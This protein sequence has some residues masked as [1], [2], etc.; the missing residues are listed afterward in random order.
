VQWQYVLCVLGAV[1]RDTLHSTQYTLQTEAHIA[2]AQQ[3]FLQCIF[4]NNFYK[5]RNFSKALSYAP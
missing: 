4:T 1:Q 2:N 3:Q 5:D